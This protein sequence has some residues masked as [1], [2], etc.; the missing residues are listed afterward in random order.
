MSKSYLELMQLPTFEE[1]YEYLKT[2]SAVGVSTFGGARYLN[3]KFYKSD[4]W[5]SVCRDV[6]LRDKNCDLGIEGLEIK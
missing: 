2:N 5:K 1:R 4:A 3:Q 6:I